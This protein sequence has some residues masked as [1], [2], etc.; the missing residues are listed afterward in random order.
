MLKI[1]ESLSFQICFI[2]TFDPK[3]SNHRRRSI[4]L[5]EIS[6]SV[7]ESSKMDP[8]R[9]QIHYFQ[10]SNVLNFVIWVNFMTYL[11]QTRL[12]KVTEITPLYR[13][14]FKRSPN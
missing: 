2:I 9:S 12:G 1:H 5:V 11:G 6:R 14:P 8:F 10:V 3:I 4:D 7:V 13:M